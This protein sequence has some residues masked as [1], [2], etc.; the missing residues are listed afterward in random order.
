MDYADAVMMATYSW[1]G[2]CMD[3][4]MTAA[5]AMSMGSLPSGR[6]SGA[7]WAVFGPDVGLARFGPAD[8]G[9]GG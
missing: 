8:V 1:V 7:G 2:A 6:R 3:F 4:T 9:T 5:R